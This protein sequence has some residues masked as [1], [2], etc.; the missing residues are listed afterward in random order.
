MPWL[1]CRASTHWRVV[2]ASGTRSIT[3]DS[4]HHTM[5]S[6]RAVSWRVK[7]VSSPPVD[8]NRSSNREP[9]P[10]N[11]V[12]VQQQVPGGRR[13]H[14]GERG[15]REPAEELPGDDPAGGLPLVP[16]DDPS[17]HRCGST[18]SP[19]GDEV[20]EPPLV[21]TPVVVHEHQE[22]FAGGLEGR[23]AHGREARRRLPDV[24][25]R[26]PRGP[27]PV[28]AAWPSL[29]KASAPPDGSLST[30]RTRTAEADVASSSAACATSSGRSAR[31]CSLRRKVGMATTTEGPSGPGR[32]PRRS[33]SPRVPPS[34]RASAFPSVSTPR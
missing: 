31:R 22:P 4:S 26:R 5:R 13:G 11:H 3:L 16:L 20:G 2:R 28:R 7:S 27:V 25:E 23:V 30:T 6:P 15:H 17:R 24:V 34:W 1:R 29:T 14:L 10:P 33:R 18:P 12:H 32:D 8:P 9:Q 19:G 21:G